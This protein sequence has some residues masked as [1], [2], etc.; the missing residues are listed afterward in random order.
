MNGF[1]TEGNELGKTPLQYE[2]EINMKGVHRMCLV[3]VVAGEGIR[4]PPGKPD[5]MM[6]EKE[7]KMFDSV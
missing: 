1:G 6:G 2:F 4:I 7:G 5:S 3:V